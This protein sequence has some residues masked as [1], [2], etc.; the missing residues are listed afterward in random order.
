MSQPP[1]PTSPPP[2]PTSSSSSSGG[3][4][5]EWNWVSIFRW[6]GAVLSAGLVALGI[7]QFISISG[8]CF[9]LCW[10]F[11][12]LF[13]LHSIPHETG[14]SSFSFIFSHLSPTPASS[15]TKSPLLL[16]RRQ[17]VRKRPLPDCLWNNRSHCRVQKAGVALASSV[18]AHLYRS[19]YVESR[20]S[21]HFLVAM[22]LLVMLL[23]S[24]S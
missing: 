1:P 12:I 5:S 11:G 7:I 4:C 9:L 22:F 18:P 16:R 2:P 14:P 15:L 19:W 23:S 6:T 13:G 17:R 10:L 24:S 20:H 8:E 3:G 21:L